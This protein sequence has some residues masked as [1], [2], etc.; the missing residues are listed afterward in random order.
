MATMCGSLSS[1]QAACAE[2]IRKRIGR[3]ACPTSCV[4]YFAQCDEMK[5]AISRGIPFY[6]LEASGYG[7]GA[8]SVCRGNCVVGLDGDCGVGRGVGDGAG[9]I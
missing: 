3:N 6:D 5:A 9:V 1:E 7:R 4:I 8:D 2:N